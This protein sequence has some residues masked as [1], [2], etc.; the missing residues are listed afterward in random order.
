M[1]IRKINSVPMGCP[2]GCIV[3]IKFM[4]R[5]DS[6][7]LSFWSAWSYQ[8]PCLNTLKLPCGIDFCANKMQNPRKELPANW[9]TM[10]KRWESMGEYINIYDAY[11]ISTIFPKNEPWKICIIL[12][13]E[14]LKRM[15]NSFVTFSR[16][17]QNEYGKIDVLTQINLSMYI[18]IFPWSTEYLWH[19]FRA[20]LHERQIKL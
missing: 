3:H 1:R 13:E 15:R 5:R 14:S 7:M 20:L 17:L 4:L 8:H 10:N 6:D 16:F 19:P 18:N 2:L 11:S 9:E 12:F